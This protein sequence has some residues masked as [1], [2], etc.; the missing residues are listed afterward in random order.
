MLAALLSSLPALDP[1]FATNITVFHVNEHS[2]GAIPVNMDTADAT[3][4]LFFDMAEVISYPLNCANGTKHHG[5]GPNPCTNPEA[6]GKDLMVNKLT[7]EVDSRFSG[8]A[9]C[10][11][12]V[13][14]KD[15]FG[16]YCKS[17]TY[18]CDCHSPGHFKPSACNQTVGYENVQ[19]TFG[20]FIGHS[21]ERSIFNP[22]PTAA[23]CY[24]ANTLKKLTPSNHGSWYSSLKEGYCGAPGAGDDCTW[25]VVRVDKIVT[26]ECHS[27]VFGDTVQGSAPPDCLDSCGAQK[28]NT[29]SPCWADCF[30]KA[31]LGPD[32]GKPGG[33]VAG[34]S[35][36]ALVAAWQKPFLSE[37][38]G[39]CPAQQEMAPW[40]KD[41]PWFAAPVEA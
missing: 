22:H 33:A 19:A 32:S 1:R 26:R 24:S 35:L 8:Y 3:G 12:G 20:K 25:R 9:A 10:N 7:L 6:A 38:E 41:E 4:D 37:A 13:D 31:A 27:K 16:G 14:N 40:F 15:P 30:Y 39:G 36:D 18:C 2:F 34:M 23:A 28:T 5:G 29:S 11:V 21:C 17:G